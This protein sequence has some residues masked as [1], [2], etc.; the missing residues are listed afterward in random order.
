MEAGWSLVTCYD[1]GGWLR[2]RSADADGSGWGH[3]RLPILP[4]PPTLGT[5]YP[6]TT[7]PTTFRLST[8]TFHP[9]F[10]HNFH[11]KWITFVERYSHNFKI[12]I[13]NYL[14]WRQSERFWRPSLY[15][16]NCVQMTGECD[17]ILGGLCP[18]CHGH[19]V[20]GVWSQGVRRRDG[21]DRVR[22]VSGVVP[23]PASLALPWL[24]EPEL[25]GD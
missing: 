22:S 1:G 10:F 12:K 5:R 14:N 17:D 15:V 4:H 16:L 3:V 25:C 2:W 23:V 9:K 19:W 24:T 6:S 8:T 7:Q 18:G 11:H 13:D 20:T 21:H